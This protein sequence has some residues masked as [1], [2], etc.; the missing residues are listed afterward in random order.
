MASNVQS[1]EV[2]PVPPV[3]EPA[4]TLSRAVIFANEGRIRPRHLEL[5]HREGDVATARP[6]DVSDLLD[7]RVDR[8]TA[9]A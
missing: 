6:V 3:R 7:R 5:G 2:I 4:H 9:V 8:G 1:R